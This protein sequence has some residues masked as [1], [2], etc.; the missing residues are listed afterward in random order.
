LAFEEEAPTYVIPEDEMI[1]S[2]IELRIN[3]AFALCRK[4]IDLAREGN[5]MGAK[6]LYYDCIE[7]LHGIED[8]LR[9]YEKA[10]RITIP[11]ETNLLR[12]LYEAI[13]GITP[14][15][16]R[17]TQEQEE[18]EILRQATTLAKTEMKTEK[19]NPPPERKTKITEEEIGEKERRY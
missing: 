9:G 16:L 8:M 11:L 3:N 5:I 17:T 15:E 14:A 1:L 12:N 4:A 13:V 7:L 6:L 10:T 2:H 19:R 18:L